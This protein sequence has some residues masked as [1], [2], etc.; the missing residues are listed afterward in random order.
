MS[1][2]DLEN[3]R[4]SPLRGIRILDLTTVLAGP[5]CTYQL[6]LLGAEVT[7]L[8]RP[9]AGDW[10]RNGTPVSTVPE[11]SAQFVAQN[12]DKKSITLDLQSEK[13]KAIALK[14][15]ARSDIVVE[16]FSAGV[17]DRLGIGYAAARAQ[18][19]DIVYCAIS[20]YGQEG[21]MARRPAYDHVVQ[22]ASGITLLNGTAET[23]PNRIG[24]P[25]FDYLAGMY[26][27]FAVMAA[28]RERDRT[29]QAQMVDVSMLDSAIVAMAS[30]VSTL[31]NAGME[32]KANGNTAASGSAASGVFKT[33]EGLLSMTANQ[34]AQLIRLC[35]ALDLSALLQEHQFLTPQDRL[36]N[37][38]AFRE[39][40]TT[41]LSRKTAA[42]WEEQL[43]QAHIP[44]A[45]VRT[46]KEV[47]AEPHVQQ[48]E[49]QKLVY[50]SVTG[51]AI[52]VPSIGFTWN[53]R[54]LGPKMGPPRLGQ[55]TDETLSALG[56]G[57]AEI[58]SLRT[59]KVI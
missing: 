12:A 28:L 49:V 38:T 7:K 22:A 24:P 52:G 51:R 33:K 59:H 26:G 15:I 17:A 5:Y 37:A 46:L 30:T 35:H 13:G 54:S 6:A 3:D 2:A 41:A 31:T 44:A 19:A 32:P 23:V 27:A 55:H 11:F 57:A 25:L 34:D 1:C 53:H 20:G 21:P 56:I 58:Q 14:L 4:P 40:F 45:R 18:R 16:N 39:R 43:S 10:A 50:D 36:K 48:R 8:E 42:E 29:G 47:L 9:G